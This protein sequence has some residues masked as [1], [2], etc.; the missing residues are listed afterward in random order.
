MYMKSERKTRLQAA[1]EI[2]VTATN[3]SLS[4]WP[5]I[6]L[7][8]AMNITVV[9]VLCRVGWDPN[10]VGHRIGFNGELL[11]DIIGTI[12]FVVVTWCAPYLA[13]L[14]LKTFTPPKQKQHDVKW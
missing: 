3:H 6:A 12:L 8:V 14:I 7:T 10:L 13:S 1:K 2:V 5:E 11:G 4:G 9:H